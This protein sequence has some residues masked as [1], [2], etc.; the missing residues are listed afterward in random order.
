M[1]KLLMFMLSNDKMIDENT[2]KSHFNIEAIEYFFT[3]Y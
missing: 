1:I 2:E 3:N